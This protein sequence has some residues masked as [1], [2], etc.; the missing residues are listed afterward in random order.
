[1]SA[2]INPIR[3]ILRRKQVESRTGLGKSCIYQMAN[4]G[5]F[6]R[7]VLLSGRAVGWVASEVDDW[8]ADRIAERDAK[9]ALF[10]LAKA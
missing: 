2:S 9:A 10:V 6:P 4:D 5:T 8:L 1:M 7:P 3:E